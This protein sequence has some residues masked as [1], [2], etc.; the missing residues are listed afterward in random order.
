MERSS[1]N[2]LASCEAVAFVWF[3]SWFVLYLD[4]SIPNFENLFSQIER[5]QYVF[6]DD[7]AF[8]SDIKIVHWERFFYLI[9]Y[10]FCVIMRAKCMVTDAQ[11]RRSKWKINTNLSFVHSFFLFI[12]SCSFWSR[13][14]NIFH[15]LGWMWIVVWFN[16]FK[17]K[18]IRIG[19]L[20]M[21]ISI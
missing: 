14:T 9:P 2:L 20:L 6:L 1:V 10:L 16:G 7:V 4:K 5:G 15:F 18:V 13:S 3:S 19:M 11:I 21:S 12:F 17:T 8:I